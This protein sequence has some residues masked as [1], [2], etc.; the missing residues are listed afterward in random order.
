MSEQSEA[1]FRAAIVVYR[2][3]LVSIG[4]QLDV[5]GNQLVM[6]HT[7]EAIPENVTQLFEVAQ[8]YRQIAAD[9][10][11]LLDGGELKNFSVTGTIQE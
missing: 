5:V 3:N 9:I 1:N 2:D 8:L 7:G 6:A 11:V 4:D 10:T